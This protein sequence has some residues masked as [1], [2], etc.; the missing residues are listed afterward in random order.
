[1]KKLSALFL[2]ITGLALTAGENDYLRQIGRPPEAKIQR[3]QGGE[4]FPPL[5]LPATPLRRSEKKRPP[6]P[7]ALIGKVVWGSYLDY[8]TA[9]GMAL[10][11]FDWNMVPADCQQL[12]LRF[13]EETK[14]EYKSQ[15]VDLA[16][17]SGDPS[18]I[19]ILF[20]SGGRTISFSDAERAKLRKYLL[21]GG[22]VWFDSVV[23]SP[24]FYRSAVKET[25]NI[26]PESPL[27]RVVPD[28]ALL[29][30]IVQTGKSM[31]N[32]NEMLVTHLEGVYVGARLAVIISP[33]GLGS[34]WD[35][36]MPTQVENARCLQ[37]RSAQMLGMNMLAY[38]IGWYENGMAY[39]AGELYTGESIS[40]AN[41]IIFA[42]VKT[43]GL[44]N[45][46]P[47]AE[48]RFMRYLAHNLK[49]D[50]G[51]EPEYID[52]ELAPLDNYPFLYLSGIGSF[53]LSEKALQRIR[54][55][56]DK[57][58][59]LLL[60]NALGMNDFDITA[61][62]LAKA[63][64]PDKKLEI[65]SEQHPLFAHA[66]FKFERSGFSEAAT[67]KYPGQNHPLLYGF[68]GERCK[69]IYSPVD[70]AGGWLGTSRPGSVVYDSET[71]LKL[72]SVLIT[73]FLTR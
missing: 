1:M 37:P 44:W 71:A 41:K 21:G 45:P 60:N 10:R 59:F 65:I 31:T 5:P 38:A 18:E 73:Y 32:F 16:T 15:T 56:L 48:T 3:R 69:L 27:I 58:G 26:L 43:A 63:L 53:K 66:P 49:I 51:T 14:M 52:P 54:Q 72:G 62:A 22:T 47:G 2:T 23:G 12:L 9:D 24:Y 6:S 35:N 33:L 50:A 57:G 36:V 70:I 8:T 19:P 61:R 46:D 17:F 11:V 13:R 4:S 28:H 64:Y 67:Q 40:D 55:Y 42:Q 34:G 30:M 68:S 7:S 20:F 25:G 29:R 39:A